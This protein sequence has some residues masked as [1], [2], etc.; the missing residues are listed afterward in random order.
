MTGESQWGVMDNAFLANFLM[1]HEPFFTAL[2]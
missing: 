1:P 2:D